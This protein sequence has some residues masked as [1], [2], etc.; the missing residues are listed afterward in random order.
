MIQRYKLSK[1]QSLQRD[2]FLILPAPCCPDLSHERG[3]ECRHQATGLASTGSATG[4]AKPQS[5]GSPS[6]P[7]HAL[8]NHH[9][10][11]THGPT[12]WRSRERPLAWSD[13]CSGLRLG[14]LAHFSLASS[15]KATC[16][17][18]HQGGKRSRGAKTNRPSN[19]VHTR[20]L[21]WL[22]AG[23][24]ARG[25]GHSWWEDISPSLRGKTGGGSANG[26]LTAE[27]SGLR[28]LGALCGRWP[29]FA[30]DNYLSHRTSDLSLNLSL[31]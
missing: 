14:L 29:H 27:F 10:L 6:R 19:L 16:S 22:C 9:S 31:H 11:H 21:G 2:H 26:G 5:R 17:G 15:R 30:T 13:P 28:N 24:E 8:S 20:V 23:W 3:P 7:S 25:G 1:K 18:G 4:G 12:A